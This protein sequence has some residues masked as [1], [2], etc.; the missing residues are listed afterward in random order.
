MVDDL[1]DD[2]V[3]RYAYEADA[4]GG[5]VPA[6]PGDRHVLGEA[7]ELSAGDRREWVPWR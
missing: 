5:D 3:A 7:D 6:D 4:V 2:L 1:A